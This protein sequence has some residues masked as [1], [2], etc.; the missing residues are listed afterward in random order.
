MGIEQ[1]TQCGV[2][3]GLGSLLLGSVI[4]GAIV[5][6]AVLRE[7]EIWRTEDEAKL[8]V[9]N[10]QGQLSAC[11]S[12]AEKAEATRAKEQALILNT[13]DKALKAH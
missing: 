7:F 3:K 4:V 10:V 11:Q 6:L 1:Y 5:S 12:I 2:W 8:L 13:L 9:A